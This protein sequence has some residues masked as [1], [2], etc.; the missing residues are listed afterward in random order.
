M[1]RRIHAAA[2]CLAACGA[3]PQAS[4]GH[5]YSL[6]R[7]GDPTLTLHP[8]EQRT[9]SVLLTRDQ[10]GPVANSRIHFE[11][12][13]GDP[14]GSSL[15]REDV[16]TDS[17]G[18]ATVRFTAST[19]PGDAPIDVVATAPDVG[20][21]AVVFSFT[22]TAP[23]FL[24]EIVG[25]SATR[26]APDGTRA[27]TLAGVSTSLALRVRE[28][29][30]DTG[31]PAVSDIVDFTLPPA[32]ASKWSGTSSRTIG[33]ETGP[34]GEAQVYLVTTQAAEGPWQVVAQSR[35]GGPAVTFTVTV[36]AAGTGSCDDNAQC[37]PGQVCTGT[38]PHC[39]DGGG[40]PPSGGAC[41]PD[42]PACGSGQCCDPSS[43][44]CRDLCP[45]SCAPGTHCE[46]GDG[47]GAGTCVPDQTAPDVTGVWLTKHDFSIRETLPGSVQD[48]FLGIRL[49]DQALLGKLT[50]PG[51][52]GWL[53]SILNS[54]VS[55]LLQQYL[56]DWVQQI[57]HIS[58]D[59]ATMLSDLR[60]EG[61]M[62][63]ARG[64][65]GRHVKGSEVWTSL[66]FYWLPLC[67]GE[68]GGDPSA[69]PDCAR[70]DL[71][72]TDAQDPSWAPQCKG[73]SLPSISVQVAPFTATVGQAGAVWSLQV[74]RRQVQ[75]KMAKVVLVL[76]DE[77]ISVVT[78]GQ[79]QC[80]E[81]ATDCN[82]GNACL[83][84]CTGLAQDID[85]ATSGIVD[86]ATVEPLC[87]E[88]VTLAG[89]AVSRALARVWPT[90]ADVLDFDGSAAISGAADESACAGDV[91]PGTCAATLDGS[92][93][94]DFFFK[95]VHQLPGRWTAKRP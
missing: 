36:Q 28:R 23:R 84:D 12:Q 74:G 87:Q 83:V 53:Q 66:V 77:L 67:S 54:F 95:L 34:G 81:E 39:A 5:A 11:F 17:S 26:V 10:A 21:D 55:R 82:G 78:G 44:V 7:I 9:L 16:A 25:P 71:T 49:V 33:A 62:R 93:S 24:L 4:G 46:P 94:G 89:T 60:S 20:A 40:D 56:P 58:D 38:P 68:I 80:I 31:A 22:V 2:L 70:I 1:L 30:A 32:A 47:C 14:A 52:P 85:G 76:V 35:A 50:M 29:D 61:S 13:D 37:G 90:S 57:V 92:W 18:V 64:V 15:D 65:D 42:A 79:F 59:V 48:I 6:S 91:A 41:D 8:G 19:Q 88:G 75:L 72:T 43:N 63:L 45:A 69:P 73:Q 3:D 86:A 51:L 27:T